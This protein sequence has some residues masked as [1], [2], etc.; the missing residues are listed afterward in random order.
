[1]LETYSL[2]ANQTLEILKKV[3]GKGMFKSI[4]IMLQ[5]ILKKD[6]VS[7]ILIQDAFY[8]LLKFRMETF[9]TEEITTSGDTVLLALNFVHKRDEVN[10]HTTI[11]IN[12]VRYSPFITIGKAL[13]AESFAISRS[14]Y[15]N[16]F[17]YIVA[18]GISSGNVYKGIENIFNATYNK[19]LVD[20]LNTFYE[21]FERIG[22]VKI[23][24]NAL[25]NIDNQDERKIAILS[26]LSLGGDAI[27]AVP[28]RGFTDIPL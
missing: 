15:S 1:M 25:F 11:T 3:R 22:S 20:S 9:P 6:D 4:E 18:S 27:I 24:L 21:V 8:Y 14:D 7:D 16:L 12:G 13:S 5:A 10:K 19:E 2:T 17:L 23:R 28:F 26:N